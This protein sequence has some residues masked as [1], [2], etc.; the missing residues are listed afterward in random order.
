[1]SAIG[2]N[3]DN[4]LLCQSVIISISHEGNW[5]LHPTQMSTNE[6]D[7]IIVFAEYGTDRGW[8]RKRVPD[9][10]YHLVKLWRDPANTAEEG[11]FTCVFTSDSDKHNN[12]IQSLWVSTIQ[13]SQ[14]K[15]A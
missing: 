3:K 14:S 12:I 7:R 11:I 9:S 8:H 1:M 4:A 10:F 13:V 6:S 2:S 15:L 5:Y